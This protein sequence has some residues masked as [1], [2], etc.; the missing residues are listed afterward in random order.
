MP[1]EDTPPKFLSRLREAARIF[2]EVA[3]L[4]ATRAQAAIASPSS[5]ASWRGPSSALLL[6]TSS[7]KRTRRR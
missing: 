4:E 5:R 7:A 2:R 1:N 3:A 6:R